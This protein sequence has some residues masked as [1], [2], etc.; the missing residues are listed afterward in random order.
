MRDH[1]P[2]T[3]PP[4]RRFDAATTTTLLVALVA[5]GAYASSVAGGFAYDD[6]SLIVKNVAM[7]GVAGW[8]RLIMQAFWP[9]T[10]QLYRP[11]TTMS[12]AL[13]WQLGSGSPGVMHAMNVAWFALCAALVTRVALRWLPPAG[14]LAAG[15]FFAVHPTHV[16]VAAALTGRSE[17]LCAAALLALTLVVTRDAPLDTRR[18]LAIA[19][20]SAA[21]FLS[22]E[23]GIGAPLIAGAA[24]LA[25][26]RPARDAGR[27]ALVAL[28]GTVGALALRVLVLGGVEGHHAHAAFTAATPMQALALALS[29]LGRGA[30]ILLVPHLPGLDYSPSMRQLVH[31]DLTL[32]AMGVVA[33][34]GTTV[35]ALRL[36]RAPR[37]LAFAAF[38]ATVTYAPVA[39]LLT[40]NGGIF[41]ER[42]LFSPSVGVALAVGLAVSSVRGAGR[43]VVGIA[44]GLWCA[45]A[46]AIVLRAIPEW[47][48]T[49]T[50]ISAMIARNPDSYRGWYFRA[51]REIDAG[52][53]DAA[54]RDLAAAMSRFDAAADM[55][56]GAGVFAVH[57]GDRSE[58]RRLLAHA[59]SLEPTRLRSR[60]LL[61]KL[62]LKDGEGAAAARLIDDGLRQDAEQHEWQRLRDSLSATP[63]PK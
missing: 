20:C 26:S 15:L 23:I 37:L 63:R 61:I 10:G 39:N 29:G 19:A 27:V 32:V 56:E 17:L 50:V 53:I 48:D 11:L 45:V 35:L 54:S 13:D 8:P 55:V 21:A 12:L 25:L 51:V 36:T 6:D 14:A 7:H 43:A 59:L 31:P 4:A 58:G 1:A 60:A 41:G 38:L 44:L 52:E 16:E 57:L 33:L 9:A 5:I 28:A 62:M 24:V 46:L 18:R 3:A 22:K 47:H 34:V 2:G 49:D 30:T 42:S 40:H